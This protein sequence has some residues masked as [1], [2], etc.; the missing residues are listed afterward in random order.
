M[1]S[2]RRA[3]QAGVKIAMGTDSGVTPHGEN[4]KELTL[5]VEGGMTPLEALTATTKTAAELMGLDA[6]LGTVETGKLADLVVVEGDP[7]DFDTLGERV[8]QV[9]IG[10]SRVV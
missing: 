6:D 4:L 7:F 9:W 5:M 2:F 1:E 3:V 8:E 10:G